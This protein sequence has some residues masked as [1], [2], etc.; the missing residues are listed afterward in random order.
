MQQYEILAVG[1]AIILFF[2]LGLNLIAS[3]KR[4]KSES[5]AN[6]SV[7]DI[8][9]RFFPCAEINKFEIYWP[10]FCQI[11]GSRGA[12]KYLDYKVPVMEKFF[13]FSDIYYENL[14]E[15]LTVDDGDIRNMTIRELFEIYYQ[16][17]N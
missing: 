4:R 13:P 15:F 14:E 5:S 17:Q 10:Q 8:R 6:F 16:R 11:V 2:V 7:E 1:F 3:L 9:R 12:Y